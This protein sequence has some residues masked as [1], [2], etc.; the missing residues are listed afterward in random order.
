MAKTR[1]SA[2]LSITF[3]ALLSGLIWYRIGQFAGCSSQYLRRLQNESHD[4]RTANYRQ[5]K[6]AVQPTNDILLPSSTR[7]P[8]L[9]QVVVQ[10]DDEE[11]LPY[12]CGIVFFYHIPSTG[13]ASINTWLRKYANPRKGYN[14][15]YFQH[16]E[17]DFKGGKSKD[18]P[19]LVQ[20]SESAFI[21]GMN[22]HVQNMGEDE[23]RI[24]H[25]HINSMHINETE[26]L[27]YQ[28]RKTVEDQGCHMINTIMLR[29]PLSH[30]MSLHKVVTRKN[31]TWDEWTAFL[32]EPSG[33]GLWATNLDFVLY[34]KGRRNPYKV[35]KEEK[36]RRAMEIL[37]RHFDV[38]TVGNHNLFMNL[39][40]NR[41]GW[42]YIEM[43]YTNTF[44]GEL[45]FTKKR[46]EK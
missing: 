41:T 17:A 8:N 10:A 14:Y 2:T 45:T 11:G 32:N 26:Q 9:P 31:S 25:G 34:N 43:P 6:T 36:V 22:E 19:T 24:A 4:T 30:T 3:A 37:E 1:H 15:S 27:L 23:W 38:V 35:T 18:I 40:L 39:V 20:R 44:K 46:V 29:D 21:K 42:D 33:R 7:H 16:W 28:W 13:G 5:P 12:K